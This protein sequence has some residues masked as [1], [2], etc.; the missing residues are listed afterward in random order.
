[1]QVLISAF[2]HPASVYTITHP[3]SKSQIVRFVIHLPDF[4]INFLIHSVNLSH[5]PSSHPCKLISPI[6]TA[7]TVQPPLFS[8]HTQNPSF[9]QIFPTIDTAAHP[10]DCLHGLGTVQR[11]C[12][13][14]SVRPSLFSSIRA[15]R[16]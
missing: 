8:L 16:D 12:F 7:I 9:P 15:R 2:Q 1:M 4:E 14:V 6:I 3:V 13:S 5:F 11:F 10:S